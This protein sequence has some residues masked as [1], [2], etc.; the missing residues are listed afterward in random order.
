MILKKTFGLKNQ[1]LK[2][3]KM[4]KQRTFLGWYRLYPKHIKDAIKI[5]LRKRPQHWLWPSKELYGE[6]GT[7]CACIDLVDYIE[8]KVKNK[9]HSWILTEVYIPQHV[10]SFVGKNEDFIEY[11][12]A[13][14]Q[15]V[16]ENKQYLKSNWKKYAANS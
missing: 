6:V 16:E 9:S 1:N 10:Q 8:S 14:K 15:Y 7:V 2:E 13:V 4:S 3:A 5:S 11:D 12:T